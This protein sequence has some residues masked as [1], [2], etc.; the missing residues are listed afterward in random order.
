MKKKAKFKTQCMMLPK[1]KKL[2]HNTSKNIVSLQICDIKVPEV[3]QLAR[4]D[5]TI[6][7]V[8]EYTGWFNFSTLVRIVES[9]NVS[10]YFDSTKYRP[11]FTMDEQLP[12][13]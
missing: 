8:C 6:D 3:Q 4:E 7:K 10:N 12:N 11:S 1:F 9:T 5:E 13:V 2:N